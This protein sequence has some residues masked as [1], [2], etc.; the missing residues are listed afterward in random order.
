MSG[1][2]AV[3]R[4]V[5][6]P[7][8]ELAVTIRGEGPAVVVL[9]GGPGC[10]HYLDED[11]LCPPGLRTI[12]PVPRGVGPSTGGPHDMATAVADLE[13][14]RLALDLENWVAVGHSW[15]SDLALRYAI[16]RPEAVRGVVG[17]AGHG[18]HRDR[19]WSQAY[20]EGLALRP[21]AP[22]AYDADVHAAL[23][24]SF[25]DWIHSPSV[26]ADLARLRVPTLLLAAE[27]D[28]RPDW[29]LRQ[30]AEL[31]PSAIFDVIDGV[32]HDLFV[33]HPPAWVAAVEHGCTW[34]EERLA[35]R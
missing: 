28:V 29:P 18:I 30:L 24:A 32:P 16:D 3:R 13:A 2:D 11:G 7:G 25:R 22:I 26:F 1:T 17:V 12:C 19:D 8:A 31:I 23:G 15:G 27:L 33:T 5:A 35:L 10:V 21:E 34:V 4:T 14:V 9:S 20:E 6:V